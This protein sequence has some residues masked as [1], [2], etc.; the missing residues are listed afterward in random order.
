[1]WPNT[2]KDYRIICCFALCVNNIRGLP[3]SYEVLRPLIRNRRL[4][5][6]TTVRLFQL[7]IF[8]SS[9]VYRHFSFL[10]IYN[11]CSTG[12]RPTI[13]I[14]I[15]NSKRAHVNSASISIQLIRALSHKDIVG[16]TCVLIRELLG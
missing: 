1:M 11:V 7:L 4:P 15:P 9:W 14:H 10:S 2:A 12:F 16:P 3:F 8:V 13:P 5:L 6:L